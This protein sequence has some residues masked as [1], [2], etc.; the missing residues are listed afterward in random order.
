MRK[1]KNAAI[2]LMTLF[3]LISFKRF[4][5]ASFNVSGSGGLK[6]MMEITG[7]YLFLPP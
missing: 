2:S 1:I 5:R 7:V 3:I 4:A 6:K